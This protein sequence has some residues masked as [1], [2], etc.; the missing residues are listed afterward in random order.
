MEWIG[1]F[2]G[3]EVF[4]TI[5]PQAVGCLIMGCVVERKKGLERMLSFAFF[6]FLGGGDC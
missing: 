5:W 6:L 1:G 4:V 2:A 3:G